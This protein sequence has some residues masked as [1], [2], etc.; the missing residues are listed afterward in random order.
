MARL[1]RPLAGIGRLPPPLSSSHASGT[2]ISAAGPSA[3]AESIFVCLCAVSTSLRTHSQR[4][5]RA[6]AQSSPPSC[7]RA[8]DHTCCASGGRAIHNPHHHP[9]LPRVTRLLFCTHAMWSL[10][11]LVWGCLLQRP[12]HDRLLLPSDRVA[13]AWVRKRRHA[14]GGR[15]RP[16][17]RQTQFRSPLCLRA[18]LSPSTRSH[19][20]Q[21]PTDRRIHCQIPPASP[22]ADHRLATGQIRPEKVHRQRLLSDE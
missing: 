2:L 12:N 13:V 18:P 8:H 16:A 3:E 21:R 20:L 17:Q 1:S 4:Q 19:Q 10:E 5:G 14:D 9:S 6:R 15:R 11:A 7:C 22:P